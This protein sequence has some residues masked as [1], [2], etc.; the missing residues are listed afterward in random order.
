M[1]SMDDH[2]S[3]PDATTVAALT[4]RIT[5][6]EAQLAALQ[7]DAAMYLQALDGVSD[8][9]LCKGPQA[10]IVYA[11]KAFRDFYGM[12]QEQIQGLIDAPFAEPDYTQQYIKDDTAVFTTGQTLTIPEEPVTRHDGEVHLFHTVKSACRDARGQ[13]VR[14]IGVS[15][16]I[17]ERAQWEEAVRQTI[18]QEEVIRHQ[19]AVLEELSTP[20]IPVSDDVVIMPIIGT[21]DST[22]AHRV[23]ESLLTGVA[24]ARARI[25]ILDI[26]GVVVV[27]TQVANVFIQAAQAVSLLGA[28]VVLTGIRPEVAQTIVGFGVDLNRIITRGTLRDGI[29]Y[30][31]QR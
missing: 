11:N 2:V 21:I 13:I 16:D 22:R 24:A 7:I 10:H 20:L 4:E 14:T 26:T 9:V 12:T 28:Q 30:A 18:Q 31:L 6:L 3:L 27:D 29:A 25:V 1:H 17:T 8:M 23:L 15:W 5:A 19:A